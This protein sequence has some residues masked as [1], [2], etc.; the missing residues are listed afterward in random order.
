M[1]EE[2][3]VLDLH[4]LV[5]FVDAWLVIDLSCVLACNCFLVWICNCS[6]VYKLA[7]FWNFRQSRV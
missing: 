7:C 1:G 4:V 2:C 5:V 3:G 6:V